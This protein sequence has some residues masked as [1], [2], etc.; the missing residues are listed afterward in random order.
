[1][2]EKVRRLVV[3]LAPGIIEF[4]YVPLRETLNDNSPYRAALA[5]FAPSSDATQEDIEELGRNIARPREK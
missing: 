5:L 2:A 4:V 3:T 1:M